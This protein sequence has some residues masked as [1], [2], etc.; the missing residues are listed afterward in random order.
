MIILDAYNA[1]PTSMQKALENLNFMSGAKKIA[2]LGDMNELGNDSSKEHVQLGNSTF[3]AGFD[4]VLFCGLKTK[5][6]YNAHPESK[7]FANRA[8]LIDYLKST[9]I[10]DSTILIKAS[11]SIGLEKIVEYL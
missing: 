9:S 5:D 4:Q 2:I 7:Y 6:S 11:R 10:E 1:N 8:Q 3:K